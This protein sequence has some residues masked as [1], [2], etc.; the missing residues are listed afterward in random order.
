MFA[1]N[2]FLRCNPRRLSER[3]PQTKFTLQS[4][5]HANNFCIIQLQMRLVFGRTV[6]S[7]SQIRAG[8]LVAIF[9][10]ICSALDGLACCLPFGLHKLGDSGC[11]AQLEFVNNMT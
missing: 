5:L 9:A 3:N 11:V 1:S 2:A 7:S 6:V 10:K 4:F 8:S